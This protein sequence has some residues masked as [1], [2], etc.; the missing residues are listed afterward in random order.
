MIKEIKNLDIYKDFIESFEKDIEFSDPHYTYSKDNLYKSF[1]KKN[2]CMFA[3]FNETEITGLFVTLVLPIDSYVEI[4][5]ALSRIKESYS[6]LIE[7][8]ENRYHKYLI[9][10]VINPNNYLIKEVL[11]KKDAIFEK[12]QLKMTLT[13]ESKNK[14]NN[15]IRL[16][17]N[18]YR[19]QYLQ[20]HQLNAYW[21]G[22]KVLDASNRFRV[23]LAIKDNQVIGYLDITYSFRENE[24]YD[25]FCNTNDAY[26]VKQDL[27]QKA[28]ELDENKKI[29]VL[30]DF[31]DAQSIEIYKSV[32]F[33]IVD[34]DS[35]TVHWKN[36]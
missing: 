21:T 19:S 9:D 1:E 23:L 20:M 6:E 10:F 31:D 22:E 15:D 34:E 30:C 26:L 28:I 13:H 36:N 4:I 3:T 7:Y 2:N 18:E 17:S 27:L 25:L 11:I 5:I 12:E 16:F 8:L 29:M 24:P 35:V 33:E 14:I 32:G